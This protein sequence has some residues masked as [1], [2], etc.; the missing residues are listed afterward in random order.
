MSDV[1]ILLLAFSLL[2]LLWVR[3]RLRRQRAVWKMLAER[4]RT[5]ELEIGRLKT[6]S[7]RLEALEQRVL[8]N[9]PISPPPAVSSPKSLTDAVPEAQKSAVASKAFET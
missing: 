7:S 4:V 6:F 8:A 3:E 5:L 9:P 2:I 1:L